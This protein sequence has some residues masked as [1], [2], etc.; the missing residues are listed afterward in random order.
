M[1]IVQDILTARRV[2][3]N[4]NFSRRRG[5]AVKS[6][7]FKVSDELHTLA[8]LLDVFVETAGSEPIVR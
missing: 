4:R 2:A 8:E 6:I 1:E 7:G 5:Y 3:H